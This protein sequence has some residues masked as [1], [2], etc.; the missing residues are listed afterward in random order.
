MKLIASSFAT[1]TLMLAVIAG[2]TIAYS[3]LTAQTAEARAKI[4]VPFATEGGLGTTRI[5]RR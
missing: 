4:V 3:V 1:A 2:P 5:R